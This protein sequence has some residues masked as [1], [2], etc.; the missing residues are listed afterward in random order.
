M[1]AWLEQGSAGPLFEPLF[2]PL[3]DPLVEPPFE[4]QVSGAN[5]GPRTPR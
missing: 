1:A 5:A 2:E 4:P 3:F